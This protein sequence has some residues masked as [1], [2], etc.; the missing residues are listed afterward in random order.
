MS[1]ATGLRVR[2]GGGTERNISGLP[3]CG[4]GKAR[5]HGACEPGAITLFLGADRW[6][7][8]NARHKGRTTRGRLLR[9]QV[10]MVR[11]WCAYGAHG[12]L[13]GLARRGRGFVARSNTFCVRRSCSAFCSIALSRRFLSRFSLFFACGKAHHARRIMVICSPLSDYSGIVELTLPS[14]KSARSGRFCRFMFTKICCF[15]WHVAG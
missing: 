13:R 15:L 5:Q 2:R 4:R 8:K 1:R 3:I 12:C 9:R 6:L 14:K 7:H 11:I 10:R